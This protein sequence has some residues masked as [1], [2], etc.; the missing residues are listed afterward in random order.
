MK[1]F[2][3][4]IILLG[5][6]LHAQTF[7]D[8]IDDLNAA[9]SGDRQAMVDS[10]MAATTTFPVIEADTIANFVYQGTATSVSIPGDATGWDPGVLPMSQIAGTN[11]WYRSEIYES[12]ARLDYKFVV[13]GTSWILDPRNDFTV[14]G[15]FGPN[16][17]LRMPNFVQPLEIEFYPGIPHGTLSDTS[18]F[19]SN[20]GDTR[21]VRVYLPPGYDSSSD[22]YPVVVVHDGLEFVTLA[23]AN[24]VLDYLI[25]EQLIEPVIGVFIPPVNRTEEY[26]GSL[27]D[28]FELFI[29]D[30]IIPWIDTRYRTQATA[31]S[32]AVMG[33]SNGGNI[34]LVLGFEHSDVFGNVAAL[35]SNVQSSL[36]T[37]A[38]NQVAP[39][40]NIYMNIGL[41]DIPVLIPLVRNFR[42]VLEANNY[43]L[44][45]AEYPDGHSW[46]FWRGFIDDPLQMFFPGPATSIEDE[47]LSPDNFQ[48]FHNYPNPFNPQTTIEF[49]VRKSANVVITVYD[50]RGQKIDTLLNTRLVAGRHKLSWQAVDLPSGVY[51]LELRAGERRQVRKAVLMK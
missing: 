43:N 16:S 38:G 28:Q 15:G 32:R 12:N 42:D 4:A 51:L 40:L 22:R 13:N 44:Q 50:I 33:A 3:L 10:F 21:T 9:A 45:Y 18:F 30:E 17:E 29:V 24:N 23:S 36:N 6:S 20:L 41:Y 8:F 35:S 5:A 11:F 37:D 25:D 34:S 47:P 48:L 27:Q 39:D 46:G 26:A 1:K 2:L 19:S 14:L 49:D 31:E 7:S